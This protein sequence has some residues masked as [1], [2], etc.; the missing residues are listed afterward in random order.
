MVYTTREY[1]AFA[2]CLPAGILKNTEEHNVSETGCFGSQVREWEILTRLTR[3][4]RSNLSHWT[5]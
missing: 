3:L 1:W 2:L 5:S 4:E